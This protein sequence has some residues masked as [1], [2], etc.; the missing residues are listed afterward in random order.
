MF[1][2]P[3]DGAGSGEVVKWTSPGEYQDCTGEAG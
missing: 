2:F 3:L 1:Y